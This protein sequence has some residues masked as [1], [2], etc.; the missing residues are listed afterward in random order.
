MGIPVTRPYEIEPDNMWGAH[1]HVWE[2]D[3]AVLAMPRRKEMPSHGGGCSG[4]FN[5]LFAWDGKAWVRV[6]TADP[7]LASVREWCVVAGTC[8]LEDA[9][10]IIP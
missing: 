5:A 10:R 7:L 8:D 1:W 2:L 3:G 9:V 4:L 6:Y